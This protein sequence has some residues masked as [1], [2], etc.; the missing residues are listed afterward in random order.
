MICND[1]PLEMREIDV[2]E[3]IY[4]TTYVRDPQEMRDT[5]LVLYL[6]AYQSQIFEY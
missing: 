4:N 1:A 5:G 3:M 6:E 2:H